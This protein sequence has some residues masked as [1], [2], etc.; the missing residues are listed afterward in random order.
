MSTRTALD[1]TQVVDAAMRRADADGL[2][3]VTMRAVAGDLGV[4]PMA[5]YNHV[6]GR[7]PL[8]DAMVERVVAQIPDTD[9]L[10]AWNDALRARILSARTT[11]EAHPWA[12]GAIEARTSAGPAVLGY[13]DSLMG[14]MFAG[15]LSADLVHEGMHV[16][17]TRMWGFTRD[18]LPTPELPTDPE[19][20]ARAFEA[21]AQHYPNIVR[22][23]TTATGAGSDC[24]SQAEFEVAL[25][26]IIDG[27]RRRHQR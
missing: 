17:S 8:V 9:A 16:L 2:E 22:M 7:E 25:D 26:I 10:S 1:A 6:E 12:W 23:A 18:V 3:S 27:L 11:I 14:I 21:Y 19:E 13:M 5:L 20:Q 24:D 15:G 4:T